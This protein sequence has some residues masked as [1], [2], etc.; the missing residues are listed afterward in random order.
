MK[1]EKKPEAGSGIRKETVLLVAFVSLLVGFL[2]GVVFSA[3]KLNSG[4]TGPGQMPPPGHVDS[5]RIALLEELVLKNP[6]DATSWIE[7]GNLYYD[8]QQIE[9]AIHAYESALKGRPDDADVWTDLG[10][11]YRRDGKPQKALEAFTK[12]QTL[13]PKHQASL[14]NAGVVLLHDLHQPDKAKA[15][16]EQLVRLNPDARSPSGQLVKDLVKAIP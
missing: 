8:S 5:G 9:R 10:V 1:K 3:Y 15:K 2:G 14:F 11:M 16:W 7:L 13:D 12:A 4:T 6:K